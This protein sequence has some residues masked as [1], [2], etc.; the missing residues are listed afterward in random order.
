MSRKSKQ[1]KTKKNDTIVYGTDVNKVIQKWKNQGHRIIFTNGCFDLLHIGHVGLFCHLHESYNNSKLV[2]G[3]NT[4]AS[5]RRLK[6]S[7]RPIV[8]LD[9]RAAMLAA[10]RYVD[11]VIPY[12]DD[13]PDRWIET[14]R[15][16]VLA[17]GGEFR[18]AKVPGENFVKSIGGTIDKSYFLEGLST[19]LR[20]EEIYEILSR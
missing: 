14:I 5:V 20:I 16:D 18:N 1:K 17:K 12:S 13:T 8:P 6:G 15:P 2:V 19:S 11:L 7:K 9:E 4:D 10:I 3:I